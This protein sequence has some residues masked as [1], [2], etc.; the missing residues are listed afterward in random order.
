MLGWLMLLSMLLLLFLVGSCIGS[1]LNVCVA[2]LPAGKSL[3][4]PPSHCGQ[5]STPI[6]SSD[7]LPLLSYWL[8]GGRCRVC[9]APFSMRYFWVELTT[10]LAFVLL[11]FLEVGLNIHRLSSFGQGG[12]WYL[13][14]LP[15]NAI[16]FL[17]VHLL[18]FCLL[19]VA[20]CC[21]LERQH[22]PFSI[23][24]GGLLLAL[25]AGGLFP[26]P[27]PDLPSNRSSTLR[28][29]PQLDSESRAT[30]PATPHS[31]QQLWPFWGPLPSWLPPG[32][33]QLGLTNV[34]VGALVGGLLALLLRLALLRGSLPQALRHGAVG[35]C[36]LGGAFLGWQPV[37]TAIVFAT[38][39]ALLLAILSGRPRQSLGL[40]LSL[41]LGPGLLGAWLGWPWLGP[42]LYRF[43]FA[44]I[45]LVWIGAGL[46]LGFGP[47]LVWLGSAPGTVGTLPPSVSTSTETT[48]VS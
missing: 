3:F 9:R 24:G 4:W 39:T 46:I 2:R 16:P 23:A 28:G 10:G 45:G 22:V 36:L 1:F 17:V 7:N 6:R 41:L 42:A 31:G 34:L 8:L 38:A 33:W 44:P 32:S 18:A 27:W 48:S 26:W 13:G 5:C 11:F 30:V 29:E 43:L 14:L 37:L 15:D 12:F 40:L 35:L 47:L 25:L 19:L 21:N 20:Y